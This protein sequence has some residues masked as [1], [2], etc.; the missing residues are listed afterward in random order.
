VGFIRPIFCLKK[1]RSS[2]KK[3]FLTD[4]S[5]KLPYF[6]GVSFFFLFI[7]LF[8]VVGWFL[9]YR[10]WFPFFFSLGFWCWACGVIFLAGEN[11]FRAWESGAGILK[12][13]QGKTSLFCFLFVSFCC[14]LG[15]F[16]VVGWFLFLVRVCVCVIFLFGFWNEKKREK[17]PERI[18]P[19]FSVDSKKGGAHTWYALH[20]WGCNPRKK[21]KKKQI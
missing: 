21:K 4:N 20:E 3:V 16:F 8:V 10:W 5:K 6:W 9:L 12:K 7:F 19:L 13:G 1:T 15:F 14:R 2:G 11:W 17:T 18:L